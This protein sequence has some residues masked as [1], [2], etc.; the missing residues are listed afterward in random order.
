MAGFVK[1]GGIKHSIR[2]WR[3]EKMKMC[4]AGRTMIH[5]MV[6]LV[7]VGRRS[8]HGGGQKHDSDDDDVGVG[9][10]GKGKNGGGHGS[11]ARWRRC[12]HHCSCGGNHWWQQRR[13]NGN[14]VHTQA[15]IKA[16]QIVNIVVTDMD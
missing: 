6:V 7:L 13:H 3:L 14:T 4:R 8:G 10:G 9:A 12:S 15:S 2:Q 1:A 16:T 11:I 5:M